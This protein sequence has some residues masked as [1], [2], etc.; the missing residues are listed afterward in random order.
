MP[1][2][3]QVLLLGA[4]WVLMFGFTPALCGE[5]AGE[6]TG[7]EAT[8]RSA[9]AG[10]SKA[11][12]DA[13]V[14]AKQLTSLLAAEVARRELA[15]IEKRCGGKVRR[16][17]GSTTAYKRLRAV[18]S[19]AWP[20]LRDEWKRTLADGK[21]RKAQLRRSVIS[22]CWLY[23]LEERA[24]GLL[25]EHAIAEKY[26]NGIYTVQSISGIYVVA[27]LST[28]LDLKA[29]AK[30]IDKFAKWWKAY[31]PRWQGRMKDRKRLAKD[32]ASL[33]EGSK[34]AKKP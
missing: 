9:V 20:Y 27:F 8:S 7:A 23:A 25:A 32:G 22:D 28:P 21:K 13:Y 6:R 2:S 4:S 12:L 14:K 19:D 33:A 29:E 17:Y 16:G 26:P 1:R 34:E 24:L 31:K 10:D 11:V 30:K 15:V 5:K 18:T 3:Q